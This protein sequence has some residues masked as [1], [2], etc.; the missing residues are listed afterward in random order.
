MSRRI[1]ASMRDENLHACLSLV[2]CQSPFTHSLIQQR[3]RSIGDGVEDSLAQDFD[4]DRGCSKLPLAQQGSCQEPFGR[5][6][7][8]L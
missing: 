3:L 4:E 8:S 6:N 7:L 5:I 2:A 1:V